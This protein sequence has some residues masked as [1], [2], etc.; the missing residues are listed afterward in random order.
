MASTS[1]SS[2]PE[3]AYAIAKLDSSTLLCSAYRSPFSQTTWYS[4][5]EITWSIPL[6]RNSASKE[7]LP[8][9]KVYRLVIDRPSATRNT[10]SIVK[11][12][13]P[14]TLIVFHAGKSESK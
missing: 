9:V 2:P 10:R 6:N 5:F 11:L 4:K 13:S 12:D 7:Y 14:V 8:L 1:V 3:Y